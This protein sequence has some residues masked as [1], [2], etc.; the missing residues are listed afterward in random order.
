M[1][2]CVC[3]GVRTYVRVHVHMCYSNAKIFD[4]D[5]ILIEGKTKVLIW[6]FYYR[7]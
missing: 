6:R 7:V 1:R 2:A 4:L 3:V 5:N